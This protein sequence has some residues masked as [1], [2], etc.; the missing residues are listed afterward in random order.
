MDGASID[1]QAHQRILQIAVR[2]NRGKILKMKLTD[3]IARNIMN[4][5]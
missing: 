4:E 1:R 2:K 3:N 5:R